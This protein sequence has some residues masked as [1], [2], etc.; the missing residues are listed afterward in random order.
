MDE[1]IKSLNLQPLAGEGGLWSPI[2]RDNESNAI[3]YMMIAP[4]FSAWHRIDESELW[5]HV[6]GEP[7]NLYTIEAGELKL[8]RLDK[9]SGNFTYRVK[10][11]TWMAATPVSNWS[12]IVCALTPPFSKMELANRSSL[13]ADFPDLTIPELFHE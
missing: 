1:L 5:V 11:K 2:Y 8:N 13:V 4:D 3:Y 10:P 9:D 7:V 12:L 6:A